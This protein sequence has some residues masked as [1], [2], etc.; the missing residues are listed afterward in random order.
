MGTGTVGSWHAAYLF[1]AVG[2]ASDVC[3]NLA[4]ARA[5]LGQ[6]LVCN[7]MSCNSF[8]AQTVQVQ[9]T[10][11]AEELKHALIEVAIVVLE[12]L[13]DATCLGS[14]AHCERYGGGR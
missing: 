9:H 11:L 12:F 14:E 13:Y 4:Q 5:I 10:H 2:H 6:S 1:G 3:G 8:N 7:N